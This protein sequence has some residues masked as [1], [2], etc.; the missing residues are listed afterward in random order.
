LFAGNAGRIDK[1]EGIQMMSQDVPNP[2]ESPNFFSA[3]LISAAIVI[4]WLIPF[5]IRGEQGSATGTGVWGIVSIIALAST[6]IAPM[7]YGW[8][9]SDRTGA[10]LI[11]ILPFLVVTGVSRII[12]GNS[13]QDTGYLTYSVFYVVSLS[14]VGGLEGFFAAKK[15]VGFMTVSLFLALLWTGIFLSGIH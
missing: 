10:I 13:P 4:L 15:T 14:L 1:Q 12:S 11:G 6:V 5:F 7:L 9:M 2:Q 3:P 8:Y